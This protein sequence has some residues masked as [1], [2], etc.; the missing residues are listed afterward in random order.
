[1][2]TLPFLATPAPSVAVEIAPRRVAAI[3]LAF[4]GGVPVIGSH[5]S[6]PLPAGA[7]VPALNAA[8]IPDRAT[9]AQA[10]GRLFGR[11]GLRPRRIALVIPD[12]VA[13]VSILRF[14]NVPASPRDLD[15]L[16]HWHV[17]KAAP[18]RIEDAQVTYARGA[19]AEGGAR[20]FIVAVA[21]RDVVQ[22]YEQACLD[23]GATA[24][25]VDLATFDLIN[26]VLAS[27]RPP[28]GDW[29]LVNVTPEYSTMGILRG[30]DLI[31]FRNRVEEGDGNLADLVHQTAMY[32]EDRLSGRAFD[33]VVLSGAVGS[34][35]VGGGAPAASADQIRQSLETRLGV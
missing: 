20:D 10:L 2:R 26:A 11:L 15:Q 35:G 27:E 1:M 3:S 25:L 18:F 19:A 14:D 29:L 12:S 21:R 28:A 23:A 24:G 7:V 22:E 30:A 17:R 16:I 34:A 13:K 31:F 8:N 6:E 9:V 33:R 4:H 32:Y 5:A